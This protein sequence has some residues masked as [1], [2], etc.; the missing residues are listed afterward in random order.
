MAVTVT[1]EAA[2]LAAIAAAI[3]A[4]QAV[5]LGRQ[6][7]AISTRLASIAYTAPDNAGI[8]A[9][10]TLSE[11]EAS[12]LAKEATVL[13]RLAD[14]DYTA[15][16]NAGITAIK[17]KTDTIPASPAQ[18]GEYTT[19]IADLPTLTEIEASTLAKESTVASL[20]D[21]SAAD[22][23]AAAAAT[24]ISVNVKKVNDVT[25]KGLGTESNPW[26]PV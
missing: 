17:A 10:P 16:D 2:D 19:A 26:G 20:N 4:D 21:I 1:L 5:E 14:A 22:I 6:D 7:V 25:I 8:A 12:T 18:A 9:L 13:S 24:P 23:L 3:R 15:P 11:I